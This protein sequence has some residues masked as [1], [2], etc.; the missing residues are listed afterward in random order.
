MFSII[1]AAFAVVRV[2][3]RE[4]RDPALENL[5]LRVE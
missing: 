2:L 4:R 5:A 1:R 3:L